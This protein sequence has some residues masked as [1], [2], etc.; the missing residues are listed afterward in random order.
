MSTLMIIESIFEK[1]YKKLIMRL[2][3]TG[4]MEKMNNYSKKP[5]T[6]TD[7]NKVAT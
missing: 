4:L 3:S 2:F 7:I 5:W 1:K 6:D